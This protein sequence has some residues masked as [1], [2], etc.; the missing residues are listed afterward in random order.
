MVE[1][2]YNTL[3][4]I[5]YSHPIHPP[6]TH[7]TV[8]MVM[9]AFVF[10]LV[11]WVFRNP[12]LT[13]TARHCLILALVALIPTVILGYADWQHYY[14]GGWLFPIKMKLALA[15][16]LLVLLVL[17]LVKSHKVEKVS[18]AIIFLYLLCL[19]NV[20]ALGYLGGELVYGKAGERGSPEA[21]AP[22]PELFNKS[23][24][25]CHPKGGNTIRANLPLGK[26][27]QLVDFDTFLSY[28]RNPKARDGSRTVMPAFSADKL[29]DQQ[30]REIYQYVNQ[31]LRVR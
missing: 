21:T 31:V 14:A 12:V 3:T 27:P 9:G 13:R 30:V 17:A 1:H 25:S 26:A 15:A 8:G 5:G 24:G 10:G 22:S 7:A 11:A 18:T 20:T 2:L 19:L 4:A 28:L 23:C 6:M 29:S 16:L